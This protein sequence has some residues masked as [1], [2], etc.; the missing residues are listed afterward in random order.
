VGNDLLIGLVVGAVVAVLAALGT[1]FFARGKYSAEQAKLEERIR[2]M[3][4]VAADLE[5]ER[6]AHAVTQ[7]NF[8]RLQNELTKLNSDLENAR[9]RHEEALSSKEAQLSERLEA[10]REALDREKA[11]LLAGHEREMA[12]LRQSLAEQ[13]RTLDESQEQAKA[14]FEA[15]S[16]KTLQQAQEQLRQYAEERLKSTQSLSEAEHEKRRIA[17][18][19][20]VQPIHDNLKRLDEQRQQSDE[21]L[22]NVTGQIGE[23]LKSLFGATT[24]LSNALKKPQTRGSF[25][26]TI[27]ETVLS[28][29][30]LQ[31]GL[32]YTMQDSSDK[33]DGKL[34]A[35]AV[36]HLPRGRKI[37]IDAKNLFDPYQD[38]VNAATDDERA[39]HLARYMRSV[40]GQI[41]A[42]GQKSYQD[43]YE[44]VDFVVM[45]L[46]HEGMYLT[47]VEQDPDLY[48]LAMTNK[49]FLANPMTLVALLRSVAYV[50]DQEK[51]NKSA[52]EISEIG[53]NLYKGIHDYAD[54]VRK[55][56]SGLNSAVDAYNKSLGSLERMV[57]S[58]AHQLEQKGAKLGDAPVLPGEVTSVPGSLKRPDL[59]LSAPTLEIEEDA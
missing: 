25:G 41:T 10:E 26:E 15:L 46:P 19:A 30:G 36:V 29:S 52:H 28:N 58:R 43:Q 59:A 9:H 13:K 22:A 35:D 14:A 44:G 55:V 1:Y 38:Y 18:E 16:A 31:E 57:V 24:N 23:Q 48:R 7:G 50:L 6:Q 3:E 39:G 12:A 20:L 32:A 2:S 47:A 40:K 37:V 54:H 56:G 27:L 51:L 11:A 42:L 4:A 5:R 34:R 45:F 21:K 49:V 17:I 53:R 8:N 33:E